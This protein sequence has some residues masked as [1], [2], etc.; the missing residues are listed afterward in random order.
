MLKE[1]RRC[2]RSF[3][4]KYVDRLRPRKISRPLL[5][6]TTVHKII[7]YEVNGKTSQEA[8]ESVNK[9][10]SQIFTA[11]I[12]EWDAILED[13]RLIMEAYRD[14]WKDDGLDYVEINGSKTEHQ[15]EVDLIKGITMAGMVD[16]FPITPDGRIW[17]GEHKSRRGRIEND[18]VRTRDMQTMLYT[19]F[20]GPHFGIKRLTGNL[21]DYIRSKAPAEP[22]ML[23]KG[24][25]SK[26]A[27]DTLPSVYRRFLAKNK[28]PESDYADILST[29]EENV[30]SWFRRCFLPTNKDAIAQLRQETIT[31]AMEMRRKQGVDRTRNLTKD[32][33]WC[34]YEKLCHAELFGMDADFIRER[35]YRVDEKT[36]P[37]LREPGETD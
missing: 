1:W 6:G 22:D 10:R 19:E 13:A 15:F 20:A 36:N 34:S 30:G 29:L 31:T 2:R 26:R 33:S 24:G 25:V 4:Y 35:E 17:L 9:G 14:H 8:I 11:E 27:I 5:F 32:C 12:D 28:L 16:A 18:S 7:D 23:K 21:W 37:E 3:A